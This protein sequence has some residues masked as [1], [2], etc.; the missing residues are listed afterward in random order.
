M[1]DTK[2]SLFAGI[3]IGIIITSV[4]AGGAMLIGS[5]IKAPAKVDS[6]V[7]KTGKTEED[8]L[9]TEEVTKKIDSIRS[10]IDYYYLEDADTNQM[11]EGIYKGLTEALGDPYSVYY[12]REETA[13]VNEN[14]VG[15]YSGIGAT[16][17]KNTDTQALTVIKCF[18]D[19]PALEADLR[20][21]DQIVAVDGT[22]VTGMETDAAVAL[23]KGEE[24]TQVELK[25]YREGET[26]YLQKT[27]TRR[28]IDI[29]TVAHTMLEDQIGYIQIASFDKTTT[30]QFET[31]YNDLTEQG[32]QGLVIDLRDNPGGMLD[33]VCNIAEYFVPKGLIVYMEDKYGQR[34]EYK[35][36]GE[37]IFAKPLAVL[38]N[39][40][41][42]SASEIFAGA[43]QDTGTG[44]VVGT[45]T[46]GKGIVQQVLDLGDGTSLKLT[47]SKY[48]TPNGNDIHHKGIAPDIEVALDEAL[49][50]KSVITI[51]E[52]NQLQRAL[53]AVKEQLGR[54]D[55]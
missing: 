53:S 16:L 36:E 24:G 9:L 3:L 46:Y 10:L 21:G 20:P 6:P 27:L 2:K 14:I 5:M 40:N 54:T 13:E 31:A 25:I 11:R 48:F 12:D 18:E 35:A 43:V 38:V 51:E 17:T 32:M 39:G 49:Y 28:S 50:G 34:T 47:V 55:Q 8:S 7:L 42:A 44:T 23:I 41:S 26:D 52:D 37:H 45:N 15:V 22:D 1:A 19:T 29:P 30:K 4:L 33:T